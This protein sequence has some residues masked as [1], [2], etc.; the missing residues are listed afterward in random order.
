MQS[1]YGDYRLSLPNMVR[2]GMA[3]PNDGIVESWRMLFGWVV[4]EGYLPLG[5]DSD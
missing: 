1:S 2:L 3:A 5:E 4:C